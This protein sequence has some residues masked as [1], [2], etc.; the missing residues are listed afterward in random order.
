MV[1][2][3]LRY[4]P[5]LELWDVLEQKQFVLYGKFEGV[6]VLVKILLRDR[7]VSSNYPKSKQPIPPLL[8]ARIHNLP[9][10]MTASGMDCIKCFIAFR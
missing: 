5:M 4:P 1:E 8:L 2:E 3:L 7:K 10:H 9:F 6:L